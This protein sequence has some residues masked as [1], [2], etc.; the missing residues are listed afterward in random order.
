MTLEEMCSF[1]VY[2]V[3]SGFI[4]IFFGISTDRTP[5][6]I[7]VLTFVFEEKKTVG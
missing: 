5:K 6:V 4:R 1:I 7:G 3:S 2:N